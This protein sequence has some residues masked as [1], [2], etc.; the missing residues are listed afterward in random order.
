MQIYLAGEAVTL[1]DCAFFPNLAYCVRL[2][3]QLEE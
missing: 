2:G 1:A 3:L